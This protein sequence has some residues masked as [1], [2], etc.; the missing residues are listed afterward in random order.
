MKN[1]LS[2]LNDH[3]FAQIERLGDED[4]KGDALVEEINRAH[5][6]SNVASQIVANGNLIYKAY[7]AAVEWESLSKKKLPAILIE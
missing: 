1:K 5:A 3:L 4:L 6:I 7:M 2:N